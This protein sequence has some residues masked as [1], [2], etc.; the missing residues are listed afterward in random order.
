MRKAP[1]QG[2][3]RLGSQVA[4]RGRSLM[5]HSG[6]TSAVLVGQVREPPDVA[7]AHS[8]A[9]GGQDVLLLTGPVSPLGVLVTIVH[10]W[11]LQLR[12]LLESCSFGREREKKIVQTKKCS[13]MA[14]LESNLPCTVTIS[15]A[16]NESLDSINTSGCLTL[17]S[18]P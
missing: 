1:A 5:E 2:R 8:V 10:V 18:L 3:S 14:R 4:N 13:E 16:L 7:Q 9:D 6:G 15:S 11:V 17:H 12:D